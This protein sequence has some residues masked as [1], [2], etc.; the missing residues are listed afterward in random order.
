MAGF[1]F[2][3][4]AAW[5]PTAAAAGLPGSLAG[6]TPAATEEAKCGGK[7]GGFGFGPNIGGSRGGTG[8]RMPSIGTRGGS[9]ASRAN[10]SSFVSGR[11]L[12]AGLGLRPVSPELEAA[13]DGPLGVVAAFGIRL[14]VCRR[15][16]S[17]PMFAS[18]AC[19][20]VCCSPIVVAYSTIL[21]IQTCRESSMKVAW[22]SGEYW[23][24]PCPAT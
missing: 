15:D 14:D 5:A 19:A 23:L 12:G 10:F 9:F 6:Q 17:T 7:L 13:V 11:G 8:S 3:G 22:S 21:P 4:G 2:A 18:A 1:D 20:A 16:I 24:W